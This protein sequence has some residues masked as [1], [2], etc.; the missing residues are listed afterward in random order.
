MRDAVDEFARH[1]AAERNRS[2]HTVRAY[3]GD[4]VSLLD[5][6]VRMGVTE[7][8]ELTIT[9]LRSWL[10]RLH[11]LGA[12]RASLARK[13]AVARTFTAWAHRDGRIAR[14]VGAALGQPEAPAGVTPSPARRPG[15]D[16]GDRGTGPSR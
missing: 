16:L 7:P 13:A 1:L 10:A 3:V 12:A 5:H 15:R 6:A 9:V 4:V 11:S 14:D 2:P 8:A